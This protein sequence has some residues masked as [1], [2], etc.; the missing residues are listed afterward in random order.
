MLLLICVCVCELSKFQHGPM[1]VQV[2]SLVEDQA[3]STDVLSPEQTQTSSLELSGRLN[4]LEDR[5][6]ALEEVSADPHVRY[7]Q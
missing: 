3:R 2:T 4:A 5:V 1:Y 7:V 6:A